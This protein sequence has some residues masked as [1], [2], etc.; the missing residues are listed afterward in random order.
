MPMYVYFLTIKLVVTYGRGLRVHN[1]D[2]RQ[3]YLKSCR[4]SFRADV[5]DS[6]VDALITALN[7]LLVEFID[8][9]T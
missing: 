9:Y 4:K 7:A 2:V 8:R 1:Y 3:R 6:L 5:K